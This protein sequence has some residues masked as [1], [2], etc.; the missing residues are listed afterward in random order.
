MRSNGIV[1]LFAAIGEPGMCISTP[2]GSL[3]PNIEARQLR[4]EAAEDEV[5]REEGHATAR[6]EALRLE[7]LEER[8]RQDFLKALLE[9]A[10]AGGAAVHFA[11]MMTSQRQEA[12][13]VAQQELMLGQPVLSSLQDL[14]E[15]RPLSEQQVP[16]NVCSELSTLRSELEKVQLELATEKAQGDRISKQTEALEETKR[17]LE[18]ERLC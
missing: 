10:R 14:Q 12:K 2:I 4:L 11:L 6:L 15:R 13:V 1:G 7:V 8:R 3:V 17:S 16:L 18:T 9:R 5:R